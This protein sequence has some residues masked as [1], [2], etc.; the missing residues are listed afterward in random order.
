MGASPRIFCPGSTHPA[1]DLA[2]RASS[3]LRYSRGPTSRCTL[4]ARLLDRM[5]S[6]S[7][8]SAK[9]STNGISSWCEAEPASIKSNR[10]ALSRLWRGESHPFGRNWFRRKWCVSVFPSPRGIAPGVP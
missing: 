7:L 1:S 6:R 4:A 2:Q 3:R 5:S 10:E 9:G 8:G